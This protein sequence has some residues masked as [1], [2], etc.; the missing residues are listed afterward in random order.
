MKGVKLV[1]VIILSLW[2]MNI[3]YEIH[4]W[5]QLVNYKS[6]F[7]CCAWILV[8][9][10]GFKSFSSKKGALGFRGKRV[11]SERCGLWQVPVDYTWANEILDHE[12]PHMVKQLRSESE[13]GT[14][15]KSNP[16]APISLKLGSDCSLSAAEGKIT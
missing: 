1:E 6:S 9:R 5:S 7:E 11:C 8:P 13:A 4:T 10:F 2:C 16:F 14:V 3:F 12:L 15:S